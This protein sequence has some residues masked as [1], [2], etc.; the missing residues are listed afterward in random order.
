MPAAAIAPV[1][2]NTFNAVGIGSDAR[3]E[4]DVVAGCVEGV[5]GYIEFPL[6]APHPEAFPR[7]PQSWYAI[8]A[9]ASLPRGAKRAVNLCGQPL[10]VFRGQDGRVGALAARCPHLGANLADGRVVH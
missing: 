1:A 3:R 9:S 2:I 6:A 8:G 4:A 7:H 10:V 5:A